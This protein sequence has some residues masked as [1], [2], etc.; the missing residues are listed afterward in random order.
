MTHPPRD[1][2]VTAG[3]PDTPKP[4]WAEI[5]FGPESGEVGVALGALCALCLAVTIELRDGSCVDAL[6]SEVIQNHL[7][8]RGWDQAA[9]DHTDE[10]ILLPLG[11]VA[12]VT[13]Q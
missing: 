8:V 12:R 3:D 11:S 2:L 7:A 5:V 13:I 10:L 1:R 9:L 4:G 6:L